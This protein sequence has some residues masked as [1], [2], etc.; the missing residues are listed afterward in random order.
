MDINHAYYHDKAFAYGNEQTFHICI[1]F[2]ARNFVAFAQREN[3][4]EFN[5][6]EILTSEIF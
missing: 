5:E 2:E 3:E 4:F 1:E 6:I